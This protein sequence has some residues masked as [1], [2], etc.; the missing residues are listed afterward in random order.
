MASKFY[1]S[2]EKR[3]K[4]KFWKFLELIPTFAGE[5]TGL[6]GKNWLE[7]AKGEGVLFG[8]PSWTGLNKI[9]AAV[10]HGLNLGF[11]LF[12]NYIKDI[13]KNFHSSQGSFISERQAE[14][15]FSNPKLCTVDA[16]LFCDIWSLQHCQ[17]IL[18]WSNTIHKYSLRWKMTFNL[19]PSKH[20]INIVWK[21]S[22]TQSFF[23][24]V[25][26][27]IR[28]EYGDLFCKYQYSV[29][30]PENKEY[31]DTFH[32]VESNVKNQK[33]YIAWKVFVFGVILIHIFLYLDWI[34]RISPYSVRM[35]ENADQ[36]NSE[37]G[38]FIR[39][40]NQN[41]TYFNVT[42]ARLIF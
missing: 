29:G 36:Y 39:S 7:E 22:K 40:D 15:P 2:V 12:L 21:V 25:F 28:A 10:P 16:S 30:I 34:L 14:Y 13:N 35:W 9:T 41:C 33:N 19:D 23:W 38:H 3:L 17:Q 4:V 18:Q 37:Y 31:L 24:S 27:R 20:A 32:A 1:I 26:S 42:L 11:L 5:R 8:P 6:R